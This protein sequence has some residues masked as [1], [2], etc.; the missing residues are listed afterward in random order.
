MPSRIK[1]TSV[2]QHDALGLGHAILC[3]RHL[4]S[5]KPFA[6]L[7][8]DVLVLDRV[9]RADYFSFSKMMSAWEETGQGQMMVEQVGID[10]VENY[11]DVDLG[12]DRA[13]K[14]VPKK[15]LSFVEKPVP[16]GGPSDL[17]TKQFLVAKEKEFED[18]ELEIQQL[19][20]EIKRNETGTKS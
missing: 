20:E 19:K 3:A 6:V 15:V 4:L 5:G 7:L 10:S 16:E 8:P 14:F 13:D 9:Q 12:E 11:G 1:V 17:I 2:R 18:L